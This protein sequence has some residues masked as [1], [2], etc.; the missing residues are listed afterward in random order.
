MICL[1][2]RFMTECRK[3]ILKV[4]TMA[5]QKRVK[6]IFKRQCELKVRTTKQPKAWESAA[7]QVVIGF[8]FASDWLRE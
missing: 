2:E 6:N 7:D 4:I 1:L 5:S 3:T 8:S